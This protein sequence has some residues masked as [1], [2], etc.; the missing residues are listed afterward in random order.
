ASALSSRGVDPRLDSFVSDVMNEASRRTG[1]TYKL[2]EGVR[3]PEQQAGKVAQGV[4]WTLHS[5][6]LDGRARDVLAFDERGN[7]IKDGTHP[8]YAALGEVYGERAADAP[9]AVKWGVVRNGAQVDPGHFE[10]S[11]AVPAGDDLDNLLDALPASAA[12]AD[13]LD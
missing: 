11:D 8:A 10:E 13:D 2:G 9:V 1:Y 7:Y 5:K 4:S 6:H 12:P 3:T